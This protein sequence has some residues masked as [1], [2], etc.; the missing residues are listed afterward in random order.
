MITQIDSESLL[1]WL[2]A[3]LPLAMS[4]G[5]GFALVAL[6]VFP[7]W[8]PPLL[9][10]TEKSAFPFRSHTPVGSHVLIGQ[11]LGVGVRSGVTSVMGKCFKFLRLSLFLCDRIDQYL[12]FWTILGIVGRQRGERGRGARGLGTL[13]GSA[14]RDETASS[15]SS[16]SVS[17]RGCDGVVLVNRWGVLGQKKNRCVSGSPTDPSLNPPTLTFFFAF[18]KKNQILQNKHN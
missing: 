5:G 13:T 6:S 3:D 16:A 17:S 1:D 11:S 9:L 4:P 10:R 18:L 2:K 12:T 14:S 7:I 8:E 15:S